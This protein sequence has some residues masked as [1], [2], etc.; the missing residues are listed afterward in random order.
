MLFGMARWAWVVFLLAAAGFGP[1]PWAQTAS[2]A[3]Q[4][5]TGCG[6][7]AG[8]GISTDR[9]QVTNS[10]IVVPCGSVQLENGFLETSNGGVWG[11]D[12][13]ETSV[14]VGVAR[15]T[16]LRL[17]IPDYFSQADTGAG[18]ASGFGDL[19]VGMKQQ[20]GPVKGWDVSVIPYLSLPTGAGGIS[21][22]GYDPGVQVPWSRS[23]TKT[24]TVAG[25]FSALWPTVSGKHD[26]TGQA[27]VYFDRALTGVW[28]V[29]GEYAG[30]F[31][32]RGGV[33]H[34]VDFGTAYKMSPHQQVDLHVSKGVSSAATDWSVGVGYSVRFQVVTAR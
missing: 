23:L 26:A 15:K 11:F 19:S 31:P 13:P 30:S 12:L 14:R 20:L 2:A 8:D 18:V 7:G 17:G 27:S 4:T 9:P 3:A 21:S 16:E 10:S 25:M 28:D 1:D 32:E 5:K 22:H 34:S 24:W 29:Y 33:Q 6:S